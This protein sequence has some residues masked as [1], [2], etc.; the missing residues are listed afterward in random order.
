MITSTPVNKKFVLGA[1]P[2]KRLSPEAK[3]LLETTPPNHKAIER[4]TGIIRLK[5]AYCSEYGI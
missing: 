5:I 3:Q 2:P 1:K 4:A